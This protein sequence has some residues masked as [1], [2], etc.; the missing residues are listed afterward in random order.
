MAPSAVLSQCRPRFQ[1]G[2]LL[3]TP[4]VSALVDTGKLDLMN[5]LSRHL[6]GDWGDLSDSDRRANDHAVRDGDRL[7]SSYQVTP[8]LK[9]WIVTEANREATTALLPDEY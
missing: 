8:D 1:A 2:R 4:G 3:M 6:S 7:L 9:I 5:Y